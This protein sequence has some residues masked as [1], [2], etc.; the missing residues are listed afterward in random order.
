MGFF[1]LKIR[2][3]LFASF[4]LLV[5]LSVALVAAS[6]WQFEAA[7]TDVARM[8]AEADGALRAAE[9]VG[10]LQA[11]RRAMLRYIFDHDEPS[12]REAATRL[13]AVAAGLRDLVAAAPPERRGAYQKVAAEVEQF[14]TVHATVRDTV[15]RFI[16]TRAALYAEGDNVTAAMRR[17]VQAAQGSFVAPEAARIESEMLTVRLENW[18]FMATKDP[19]GPAIFDAGMQRLEAEIAQTDRMDLS[20]D[21]KK[22]VDA[23]KAALQ[24]YKKAVAWTAKE[25]LA[26]D[27]AYYKSVAPQTRSIVDQLETLKT[28]VTTEARRVASDV[29]TG[30]GR[31]AM[32][33]RIGGVAA[34]LLGIVFALVIGNAISRPIMAMVKTMAQLSGGDTTVAIPGAGRIDEIGEMAKAVE[35]FR[36][37]MIEAARLREQQR[38]NEA[39]A[40]QRRAGDM[41]KL[42]DEFENA[43]GEIIETVSSAS[44]QLEASATS[45]TQTARRSQAVTASVAAASEQASANVQ[46]VAFATEELTSSVNEISRQVQESTRIAGEAVDQANLTNRRIEVLAGAAAKIGDVVELINTIAGQTNLLALNATIE[47]ARAGDA[48]RGFAVVATEVKALAHQTARATEDISRQIAG[49]Q[50]ATRE[51]VAAIEAIGSTIARVSEI[52]ATIASAVEEQGAATAEIARNIQQ[53]AGGTREVS[54]NIV[55]VE[56]GASETGSAS[57]Q[58]L[59]AATSLSRDSGLLREKVSHFLGTVRAA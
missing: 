7:R 15:D 20:A 5:A 34:V 49:M 40:A 28:G 39:A 41:R 44:S 4:G 13:D 1:K 38:D 46:S 54:Q 32:L 45:M 50:D 48:G 19:K 24:P 6:V 22:A 35:V 53:A 3:R 56:R 12:L 10:D 31:S 57:T 55:E 11:V 26:A 51:S 47:A 14:K 30:I 2:G 58:V 16:E 18:R 29:D 37:G 43:V 21:T 25:L 59:S 8:A 42:A 17:L 23:V 36:D 27:D 33:D 9:M 52:A